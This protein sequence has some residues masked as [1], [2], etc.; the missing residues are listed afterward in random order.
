MQ[1]RKSFII[2]ALI[3]VIIC[4]VIGIVAG[5]ATAEG[6]TSWFQTIEK[7]FFNPPGWL[8]APVWTLL[9]FLMGISAA[10]VWHKGTD[11]GKEQIFEMNNNKVRIAL[12]LFAV[13]L[14]LNFCWSFIFF[15]HHLLFFAFIEIITLLT[16]I[17]LTTIHFYRIHK[18]AGLLMIPYILWVSF[19]SVLNFSLWW[20]NK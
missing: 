3:L 7:P 6:V 5:L 15:K 8:F 17:I 18:I 2:K 20:L 13:Q 10:L 19:A 14:I 11:N 16:F 12:G 4:E 9:Y 1:N